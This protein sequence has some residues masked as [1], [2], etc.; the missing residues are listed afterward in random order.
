MYVLDLFTMKQAGVRLGFNEKD[1]LEYYIFRG[2]GE[3]VGQLAILE[4]FRDHGDKISFGPARPQVNAKGERAVYRP[5]R[6][7]AHMT[8][9]QVYRAGQKRTAL[10]GDDAAIPQMMAG[11]SLPVSDFLAGK[12][13]T[14][15]CDDGAAWNYSFDGG[16]KLRWR[17]E[18]ETQWHSES[19]RAFE[20]DEALIFFSHMHSGTRPAESVQIVLDFANGLATCVNSRMGSEYMANEV[21]YRIVFGVI[22]MKG[23][24]APDTYATPLPMNWWDAH[25]HGR[26][27]TP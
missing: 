21:G 18:G 13:L 19:Y 8:E 9:E 17:K 20:A 1:Q 12:E 26:I 16:E 22:E 4:P 24:E 11:N 14:V 6:T 2:T 23:L 25:S 27:Q 3:V 5:L 10:F 15:R 7:M